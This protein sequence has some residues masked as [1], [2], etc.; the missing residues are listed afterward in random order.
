MTSFTIEKRDV[1]ITS[2]N[3]VLGYNYLKLLLKYMQ[4]TLKS[5][6]LSLSLSLSHTPAVR[7]WKI[8]PD[9]ID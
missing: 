3:T 7:V 1:T 8:L 2:P 5:Q 4:R 6:S 9:R